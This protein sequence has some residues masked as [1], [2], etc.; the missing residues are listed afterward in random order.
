MT[1][2]IEFV[3]SVYVK[4]VNSCN[5]EWVQRALAIKELMS[6]WLESRWLNRACELL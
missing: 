6:N 2:Q 5:E 1:K 3:Q 4:D